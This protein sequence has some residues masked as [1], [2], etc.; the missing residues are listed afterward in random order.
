[1]I[2]REKLEMQHMLEEETIM[3]KDTSALIGAQKLFYEQLQER[4]MARRSSCN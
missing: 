4:I 1:M 3:M 2:E